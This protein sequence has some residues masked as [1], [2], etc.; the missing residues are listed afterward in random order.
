MD[1]KTF[2][3]MKE[4]GEAIRATEN[5]NLHT[6][7]LK[8]FGEELM[9]AIDFASPP[10]NGDKSERNPNI[11]MRMGLVLLSVGVDLIIRSAML[12]ATNDAQRGVALEYSKSIIDAHCKREF[13]SSLLHII[14]S[15]L[16]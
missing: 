4:L 3:T 1:D 6:Q 8:T 7:V 10:I 2:T 9:A 14:R 15:T 5:N 13:T 11:D 12:G 16:K